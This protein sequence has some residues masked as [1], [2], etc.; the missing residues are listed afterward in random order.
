MKKEQWEKMKMA[1]GEDNND[2]R[3]GM[4]GRKENIGKRGGGNGNWR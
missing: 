4:A 1:D 2:R 3:G